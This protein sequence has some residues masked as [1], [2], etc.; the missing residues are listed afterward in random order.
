MAVLWVADMAFRRNFCLTALPRAEAGASGL[1]RALRI[2][3]PVGNW[4]SGL[5]RAEAGASGLDRALRIVGP[6][7]NWLLR[8]EK[9]CRAPRR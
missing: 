5:P 1:D 6:V 9:E 3:G 2:V 8:T 4:L 7:G